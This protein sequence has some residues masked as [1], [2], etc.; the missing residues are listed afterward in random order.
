[1]SQPTAIDNQDKQ[2]VEAA[3]SANFPGERKT[4]PSKTSLKVMVEQIVAGVGAVRAVAGATGAAAAAKLI[5][6]STTTT[7]HSSRGG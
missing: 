6:Q 2:V 1:M 5:N 4:K 3:D 7:V